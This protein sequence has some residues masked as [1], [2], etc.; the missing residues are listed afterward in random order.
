LASTAA[1]TLSG[2]E[3]QM[4][5]IARGL[6]AGAKLLMLDEPSLG[7]LPR[8]VQYIFEIIEQLHGAGLTILLGSSPWAWGSSTALAAL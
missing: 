1:G 5:A 8:F 4:L 6:M 7:L 3:Q 2:G